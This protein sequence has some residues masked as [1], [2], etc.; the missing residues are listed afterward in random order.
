MILEPR[1][2]PARKAHN[3]WFMIIDAEVDTI[4][5]EWPEEWH[6]PLAELLPEDK[7]QEDPPANQGGNVGVGDDV[8]I[9]QGNNGGDDQ[10]ND[11][12]SGDGGSH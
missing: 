1:N 5:V 6:Y 4:V 7:I 10:S 3:T 8:G 2:D 12:N 11:D 9:G